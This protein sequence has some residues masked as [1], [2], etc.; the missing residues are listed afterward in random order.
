MI[1][2]HKKWPVKF[3]LFWQKQVIYLFCDVEFK[4]F[5]NHWPSKASAESYRVKYAKNLQERVTLLPDDYDYIL[6]GDFNSDYNEMQT[7]KTLKAIVS[8]SFSL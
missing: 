1:F 3:L 5:N 2:N 7:F 4:V 6:I 8:I